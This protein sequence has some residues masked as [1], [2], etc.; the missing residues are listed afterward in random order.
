MSSSDPIL[1]FEFWKQVELYVEPQDESQS[2]RFR[3]VG[4]LDRVG[5]SVPELK[6][7]TSGG[8][9]GV[10]LRKLDVQLSPGL[11]HSSPSAKLSYLLLQPCRAL[12]TFGLV[13]GCFFSSSLLGLLSSSGPALLLSSK[14]RLILS[15]RGNGW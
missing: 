14:L 10:N 2:S 4:I 8:A 3:Q 6:V 11:L 13:C 7:L 12:F 1:L 5:F 15:P 9:T